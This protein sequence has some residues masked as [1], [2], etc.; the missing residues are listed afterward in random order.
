MKDYVFDD[1]VEA[2]DQFIDKNS[3]FT[4]QDLVDDLAM[5]EISASKADIETDLREN[6]PYLSR[7]GR[8]QR[9]P[10]N[11]DDP[12]QTIIVYH[13]TND[14]IRKVIV[15]FTAEGISYDLHSILEKADLENVSLRERQ[16]ISDYLRRNIPEGYQMKKN[17]SKNNIYEPIP[18][19][20]KVEETRPDKF[21]KFTGTV[22]TLKPDGTVEVRSLNRDEAEKMVQEFNKQF[23][24]AMADMISSFNRR[25]ANM[26]AYFQEL[27][28]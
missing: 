10:F 11:Y 9:T 23:D 15:D 20:V 1:V 17:G 19:P 18:V 27:F 7:E 22:S 5:K 28:S 12:Q 25:I 6:W 16:R 14:V 24:E 2:V 13:P 8:Y 4:A 3:A 21:A 26:N